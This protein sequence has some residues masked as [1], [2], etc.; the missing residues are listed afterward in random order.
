MSDYPIQNIR[1]IGV[2]FILLTT[3]FA[4]INYG[5]EAGAI[6]GFVLITFHLIVA[7]Y[8]GPYVLWVIPQYALAGFLAGK[9]ASIIDLGFYLA[10]LMNAIGILCTFVFTKDDIGE[11]VPY[12]I[13]NLIFNFLIFKFLAPAI[14]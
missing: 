13:T 7:Q 12:A 4:G 9:F 8:M 11:Y 14:F 2:E 5:P 10:I 3:V 1:N 6:V